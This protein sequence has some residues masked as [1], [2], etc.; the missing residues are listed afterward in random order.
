MC[1]LYICEICSV[2]TRHIYCLFLVF[3]RTV[4]IDYSRFCI[5]TCTYY[6]GLFIWLLLLHITILSDSSHNIFTQLT[7]AGTW[8]ICIYIS[9]YN[10][11]QSRT[12]SYHFITTGPAVYNQALMYIQLILSN[13]SGC[14][15]KVGKGCTVYN[16]YTINLQTTLINK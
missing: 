6:V 8:S 1:W 7:P 3:C 5:H 9:I 4:R 2:G 13:I 15:Q 12:R 14:A 11:I 16:K 10:I